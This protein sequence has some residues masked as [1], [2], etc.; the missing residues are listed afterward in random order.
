VITKN[1]AREGLARTVARW[2]AFKGSNGLYLK[3]KMF[4]RWRA[5]VQFKKLVRFHLYNM[6][7]KLKPVKADLS[8][9]FNRW[10]FSTGKSHIALNGLDKSVL[11]AK[12]ADN[13]RKVS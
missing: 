11:E 8:I 1:K 10:K 5:F 3:P 9:A 12:C 6:H 13:A 7:N 4:D 2:K